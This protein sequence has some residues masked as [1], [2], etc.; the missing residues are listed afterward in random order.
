MVTI[1][2]KE[3]AQQIYDRLMRPVQFRKGEGEEDDE[4]E[5]FDA[6]IV[7]SGMPGSGKSELGLHIARELS[8]ITQAPFKIGRHVIYQRQSLTE[9]IRTEP[10]YSSLV[11]DE[12][13]NVLFS[14]D[15][16]K[17]NTLI[18]VLNVCR[19][20]NLATIFILPEFSDLETKVRKSRINIWIDVQRTGVALIL[21]HANLI[22]HRRITSD[23]RRPDP[24]CEAHLKRCHEGQ[25]ELYEHPG[26]VGTLRW[27]QLPKSVRAEYDKV[28]EEDALLAIE[29]KKEGPSLQ[30]RREHLVDF[31]LWHEVEG[32]RRFPGLKVEMAAYLGMNKHMMSYYLGKKRTDQGSIVDDDHGSKLDG[33]S[34]SILSHGEEEP[35]REPESFVESEKSGY[36]MEKVQKV[37][38]DGDS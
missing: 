7:I 2:P 27:D 31:L 19:S 36:H 6:T 5:G 20:R 17:N 34:D 21:F 9:Q 37:G 38:Y 23:S 29:N 22:G 10:K 12:A 8:K 28:K 16:E 13:I 18:K 33:E 32:T 4:R 1:R 24:W 3:F 25:A 30:E 15:D 14:R 11:V 35:I 26:Y